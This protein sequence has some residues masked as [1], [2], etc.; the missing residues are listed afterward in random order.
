MKNI[1]VKWFWIWT[2]GAEEGDVK[3]YTS[4]LDL[5]RPYC[6]AEWK[7]LGILAEDIMSNI[8]VQ[9]TRIRIWGLGDVV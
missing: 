1:S 8:S 3:I 6:L 9:L 7:H 2:S 5:C 4:Y